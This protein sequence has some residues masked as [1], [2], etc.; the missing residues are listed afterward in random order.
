MQQMPGIKEYD[1]LKRAECMAFGKEVF[2][3]ASGQLKG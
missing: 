3:R 1:N 2:E